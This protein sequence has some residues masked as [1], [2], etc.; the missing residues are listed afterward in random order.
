MRSLS[1][2][3]GLVFVLLL[4]IQFVAAAIVLAAQSQH[5][6]AVHTVNLAGS[7]RWLSQRMVRRALGTLLTPFSDA[8]RAALLADAERFDRQLQGLRGANDRLD[9]KATAAPAARVA[10]DETWALWQPFRDR[11]RV[12][13][14]PAADAAAVEAALAY[15]ADHDGALLTATDQVLVALEHEAAVREQRLLQVGAAGLAISILVVLGGLLF[16]RRGV[17]APL[18]R[19]ADRLQRLAAGDGMVEELPT[20]GLVELAAVAAGY[21]R[22]VDTVRRTFALKELLQEVDH[23]IVVNLPLAE[24]LQSAC[25]QLR[26]HLPAVGVEITLAGGGGFPDLRALAGAVD[27]RGGAKAFSLTSPGEELGTLRLF[28]DPQRPPEPALLR[29]VEGFAQELAY[30]ILAARQQQQLH[31][32]QV[33]L[34]WTANAVVIT[35]NRGRIHWV[36]P[37]FTRLTGYSRDEVMG[38]T[39]RILKSGLQPAAVYDELWATICAG[40][41]WQGVLQN[42]RKDGSLY[43]S[44]QTVT[45]VL[46]HEGEPVHFVTIQ[47][48]VTEQKQQEEQIRH[49][50]YHDPLTDLPNRR[51]LQERLE[52]VVRQARKDREAALLMLDVDNFKVVNDSL[53]HLAGD[54]LL[55]TLAR[56]LRTHLRP[57]DLLARLGGDEFAL[58][59]EGLT[60]SEARGV[61]EKLLR[62]V[63]ESQFSQDGQTFPLSVSIGIARIDGRVDP[64]SIMA[65]AD[66]ALYT[67]KE[68]GRN[69]LVAFGSVDTQA[70]ALAQISRMAALTR[71]ALEQQRLF[72]SL[73]PVVS[74]DRGQV[75]FFEALVR[76]RDDKGNTVPAAAFIPAAARFGLLP[77]LD[78]WVIKTALDLLRTCP[79]LRLFVNLSG[80]TLADPVLLE[81]LARR[82]RESGVE[83]GRLVFEITEESALTDLE[84][85]RSWMAE[86]QALGC[87]FALDDF[88]MGYSSFAYLQSLPVDYIKIDGSFIRDL[89]DNET[90]QALVHAIKTVAQVLGREV[91]AEWV[92]NTDIVAVLETLGV[93]YGQG[94]CW[95]CPLLKALDPVNGSGWP[96]ECE[97]PA[98]GLERC[99]MLPSA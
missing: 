17:V 88:G 85:I 53:G 46:G 75:E 92:E 70:R 40:R 8:D 15:L 13:A 62:A 31:L 66:S 28:P 38:Q 43:L 59:V 34:E 32:M 33:A 7:Q 50:A 52:Q 3:L 1:S 41:V 74:L 69:R 27:L 76:M 73:Q 89:P 98:C 84:R 19:A 47:Q 9:L 39:P 4:L 65:L 6:A 24:T 58:L 55:V 49:M 67:A 57:G 26:S 95:H 82:V 56:L 37:A 14:D 99:I 94:Y 68:M 36:N 5:A 97:S 79:R 30:S 11:I 54:E 21:N 20:R 86:M 18:R 78:R 91:V 87:R 60:F 44:A 10:L 71:E 48:D 42:R 22:M 64:T 23:R 72:L 16:L 12:L 81:R 2:R 29:Q 63:R 77:D 93:E 61:G 96:C 80:A 35:D 25:Q 45:P 51:A 90:N 83:T